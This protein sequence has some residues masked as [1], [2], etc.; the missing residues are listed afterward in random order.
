MSRLRREEELESLHHQLEQ[1]QHN[2]AVRVAGEAKALDAE[3]HKLT[4]DEIDELW[5]ILRTAQQHVLNG[6]DMLREL[7]RRLQTPL[8]DDQP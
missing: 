7:R 2:L 5:E 6:T 3:L 8:F 4:D 1:W